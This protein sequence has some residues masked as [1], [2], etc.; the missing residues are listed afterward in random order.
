MNNRKAKLARVAAKDNQGPSGGE[1]IAFTDKQGGSGTDPDLESADEFFDPTPSTGQ[2]TQLVKHEPGQFVVLTDGKG[3]EIGKGFVHQASGSWSGANL[4]ETGLCV[5]DITYL[6][7]DK[8]TSLPH[9]CHATGTSY[10]HSEQIIG[11]KRV[12]WDSSKLVVQ[13]RAG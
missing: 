5:V 11:V 2:P 4:D 8:W 6:K 12:L 3:D 1:N 9:P 10:G 7:V 13:Q